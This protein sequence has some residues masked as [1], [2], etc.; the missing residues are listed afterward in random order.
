M[1]AP[2]LNLTS[3]K[4][5]DSLWLLLLTLFVFA[6]VGCSKLYE[7]DL[8]A[9][10]EIYTSAS[11]ANGLSSL[12]DPQQAAELYEKT[13][14]SLMTP[15]VVE[16]FIASG[17]ADPSQRYALFQEAASSIGVNNWEC[18]AL[19]QIWMMDANSESEESSEKGGT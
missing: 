17:T 11:N 9:I 16:I 1:A 3:S 2:A 5:R 8:N 12:N 14:D 6:T 7:R 10:C 4:L 15:S 19:K 13:L 18:P